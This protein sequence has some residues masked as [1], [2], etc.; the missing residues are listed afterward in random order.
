MPTS[1]DD[2]H[3]GVSAVAAAYQ[4][5]CSI[6]SAGALSCFGSNGAG[7]LGDGTLIGRLE[8]TRVWLLSGRGDADCDTTISSL[9]AVLV[10]QRVAGLIP[11]L[12]CPDA[13]AAKG[14]EFSSTDALAVLQ[15]SAG[16]LR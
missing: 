11:Q 7:Q 9:D 14:R 16:L 10:L 1:I 4:H 6:D 5:A 2:W 3:S 13:A 15:L 12:P 8:A